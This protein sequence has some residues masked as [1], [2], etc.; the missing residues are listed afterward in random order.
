MREKIGRGRAGRLATR[1]YF[2]DLKYGRSSSP[3]IDTATVEPLFA[4]RSGRDS[5]GTRLV[6]CDA[7]R[8]IGHIADTPEYVSRFH[9]EYNLSNVTCTTVWCYLTYYDLSVGYFCSCSSLVL[10]ALTLTLSAKY[11]TAR[12]EQGESP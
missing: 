11:I 6:F 10:S 12:D 3:I 7:N 9:V 5:A 4:Q 8:E 1:L 2:L